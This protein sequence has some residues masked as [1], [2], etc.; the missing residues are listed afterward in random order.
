MP[1][2]LDSFVFSDEQDH[3][4][5]FEEVIILPEDIVVATTIVGIEYSP[6]VVFSAEVPAPP[7][8]ITVVS[9]TVKTSPDGRQVI[10]VIIEVDDIPGVQNY[11]VRVTAA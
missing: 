3:D 5:D 1:E 8:A 10:N 2:G 7:A 6:E 9:Q 4:A 11:D